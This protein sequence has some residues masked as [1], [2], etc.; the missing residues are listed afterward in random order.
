MSSP[1]LDN[2]FF[3]VNL[4]SELLAAFDFGGFEPAGD[5]LFSFGS[6]ENEYDDASFLF[7][8]ESYLGVGNQNCCHRK[9]HCRNCQFR[10][11]SVKKYCWY[12]EFLRPGI[13]RDLMHELSTSDN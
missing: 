5:L 3:S 4:S 1:C 2:D 8:V 7:S 13:T 10:K 11:K 12:R 9:K 6:Y